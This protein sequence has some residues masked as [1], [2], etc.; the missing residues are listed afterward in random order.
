M[1]KPHEPDQ[2]RPDEARPPGFE[3]AEQSGSHADTAPQTSPEYA[4][5]GFAPTQF[6]VPQFDSAQFGGAPP[7]YPPA[8]YPPPGYPPA[9]PPNR[10][11]QIL[12]AI[13]VPI[14]IATLVAVSVVVIRHNNQQNDEASPP[15]TEVTVVEPGAPAPQ[16][17]DAA[18]Q[19]PAPAPSV[20]QSP[21][22]S[23]SPSAPPVSGADARGFA[24]GPRCNA[25]EDPLVFIGYTARS[26]VVICQVGSQVGRNY[27]KG[28]ANGNAIEIG[29]PSRSGSTF[30]AVNGSVRYVVS[31]SSLVITENGRT[32]S[33]EPMIQAWVD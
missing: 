27:Y 9:P 13:L 20:A 29:Y 33:T 12:A 10:T 28:L 25:P 17:P 8:G 30:T 19:I 22:P 32:L 18:G 21:E 5:T 14:V 24:S 23:P 3:T 16:E 4:P 7:G 1:T 11:P 31:P 2:H 15:P 26:R 6:G